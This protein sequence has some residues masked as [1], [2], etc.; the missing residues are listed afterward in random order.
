MKFK[1]DALAAFRLLLELRDRAGGTADLG[2]RRCHQQPADGSD[3]AER[4]LCPPW[5]WPGP[6]TPTCRSSVAGTGDRPTVPRRA[7]QKLNQRPARL[8]S[9]ANLLR[10]RRPP[11]SF[12]RQPAQA[13]YARPGGRRSYLIALFLTAPGSDGQPAPVRNH[14]CC[15]HPSQPG[16][17]YRID[18]VVRGDTN[19]DVLK[20][21]RR[22]AIRRASAGGK[23]PSTT[24]SSASTSRAA[25][26]SESLRQ[27]TFGLRQ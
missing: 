23:Q 20:A 6:I 5:C 18:H 24:D 25:R 11:R 17:S 19:A 4:A 12:H 3:R 27:T 1:Q 21:W 10:W 7:D 16:D 14:Q 9:L 15:A 26:S 2:L 8:T 13:L 22:P